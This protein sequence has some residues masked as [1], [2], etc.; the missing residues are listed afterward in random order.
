MTASISRGDPPADPQ[1]DFITVSRLLARPRL[2]YLYTNLLKRG[3]W[4]TTQALVDASAFSQSTVYDDL[5]ALRQTAL[6]TIREDGRER[7]YRAEPFKIG[8][9]TDGQLTTITPTISAIVGQQAVDDDVEQFVADYGVETLIDAVAYVKPYI[10]GRMTEQI[11]ARELDLPALVGTT[12]LIA[13]EDTVRAMQDIDPFFADVRDATEDSGRNPPHEIRF[14]TQ[15]R[16]ILE[17]DDE[18]TDT[19]DDA[20]DSTSPDASE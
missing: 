6:M 9:I 13:L 3:G 15:T 19:D 8:M 12:I 18:E 10:D 5:R 20:T 4:T 11:A 16:V 2:A 14:D 1:A 17:P 7:H